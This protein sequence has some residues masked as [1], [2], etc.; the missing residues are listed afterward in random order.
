MGGNVK[1]RE[2]TSQALREGAPNLRDNV[3][4][5]IT[6]SAAIDQHSTAASGRQAL[7]PDQAKSMIAPPAKSATLPTSAPTALEAMLGW[8]MPTASFNSAISTTTA[9]GST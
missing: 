8:R 2:K 6:S 5:P 1:A 9:N 4:P 3:S 7:V